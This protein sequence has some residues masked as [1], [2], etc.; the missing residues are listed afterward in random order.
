MKNVIKF[1]VGGLGIAA[2]GTA[3]K[4]CV[5]NKKQERRVKEESE[6]IHM[7]SN[8]RDDEVHKFLEM[9]KNHD[10]DVEF[11]EKAFGYCCSCEDGCG[12]NDCD[13]EE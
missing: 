13:R 3:I 10:Y 5:E 8:L 6:I 4:K 12:R 7:V 2:A 1:I 9:L 11:L